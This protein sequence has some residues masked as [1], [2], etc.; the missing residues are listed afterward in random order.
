MPVYF[1]YHPE[2]GIQAQVTAPTTRKARTSYMDYL[3]RNELVPWRGRQE[4]RKSIIL[5]QIDPGST[6]VDV[7]INYRPGDQPSVGMV[8]E[9]QA[10]FIPEE[11]EEMPRKRNGQPQ[12]QSRHPAQNGVSGKSRLTQSMVPGKGGKAS[13]AMVP[14][15]PGGQTS[16]RSRLSRSMV[17]KFP[18]G[19]GR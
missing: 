1:A 13:Q 11:F 3:T 16:G 15:G 17:P 7:E 18:G 2:V 9:D 5:D 14:Q 19:T 12:Q 6:P 4:F 10:D 8:G